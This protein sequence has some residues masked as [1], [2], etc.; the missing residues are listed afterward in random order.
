MQSNW[1]P[2]LFTFFFFFFTNRLALSYLS[3]YCKLSHYNG[4]SKDKLKLKM[5]WHNNT[6]SVCVSSSPPPFAKWGLMSKSDKTVIC[7]RW[8]AALKLIYE[9]VCKYAYKGPGWKEWHAKAGPKC[10]RNTAVINAIR[11]PGGTLHCCMLPKCS[12]ATIQRHCCFILFFLSYM[13]AGHVWLNT[14]ALK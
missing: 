6:D 3:T 14:I 8:M 10:E 1:T 9:P 11:T 2:T 12:R 4:P 13:T 5:C 7:L